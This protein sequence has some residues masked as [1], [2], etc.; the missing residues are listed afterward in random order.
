[1]KLPKSLI[2]KYGISKKAWSV[3]RGSKT[4]KT[5]SNTMARHRKHYSRHRSRSI[6]GKLGGMLPILGGAIYGIARPY[7]NN[8]ASPLLS[9]M[10]FGELNNEVLMGGGATLVKMLVKNPTVRGLMTPVQIIEAASA[11]ETLTRQFS[12]G[13]TSSSNSGL[14]MFY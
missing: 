13:A 8:A 5:G 14:Q 6:G 7:L 9:K 11:A 3:F 4:K 10:P 2:K 12:G 1:M